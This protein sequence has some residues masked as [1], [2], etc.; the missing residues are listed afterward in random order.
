MRRYFSIRV[1]LP[2]VTGL[3]TLALVTIFALHALQAIERREVVRRIPVIVDISYDLF[4][5]IQ[6]FRL[7]RGAVNRALAE[8]DVTDSD[9]QNQIAALR[10]NAGK[11]LDLALAKLDAFEGNGVRTE[12]D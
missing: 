8:P 5:A 1:L 4:A 2:T 6:D 3:M 10:A 12:I 11:A 9:V 7:E